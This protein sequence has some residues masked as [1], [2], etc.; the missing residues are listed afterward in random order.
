MKMANFSYR[1]VSGSDTKVYQ[2]TVKQGD[3]FDKI[4]KAQG[5]TVE[6]MKKLNPGVKVLRPGQ[7]LNYQKASV[8]RVI[9]SWQN[10]STTLIAQSYNGG[11]DVLYAKKLDYALSLIRK[12]TTALCA[13]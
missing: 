1:S 12:G 6:I 4:A 8:R 10:I 13:K 11:G 9:T 5:S 7:D 3:S 2:V